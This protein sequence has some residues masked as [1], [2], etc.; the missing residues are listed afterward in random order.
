MPHVVA[1][2]RAPEQL[3]PGSY[4][5]TGT[6]VAAP[7][8]AWLGP[9]ARVLGLTAYDLRLRVAGPLPWVVA[10]AADEDAARTIRDAL[11]DAGCGATLLDLASARVQSSLVA[12]VMA[13]DEGVRLEPEGLVVPYDTLT[14]VVRATLEEEIGREVTRFGPN[15]LQGITRHTSERARAHAL[16]LCVRG[17]PAIRLVEGRLA[18]PEEEGA[19]VRAR[20]DAFVAHARSRASRARFHQAFV[21]EPRKRTT[22]RALTHGETQRST[23]QG[24]VDETD[25]AV[26]LLS[27]ALAEGQAS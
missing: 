24:N 14:L 13:R 1:I 4:R 15:D 8:D 22:L 16:Y 18:F 27:R 2:T 10:R 12:R 23:L 17:E 19:T 3:L 21:D 25:L 20:F 6:R 9:V 7:I 11:R 26:A 5:D